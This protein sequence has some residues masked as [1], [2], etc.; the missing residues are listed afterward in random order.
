[1]D[2]WPTPLSTDDAAAHRDEF[3]DA[4]RDHAADLAYELARLQGAE[5]GRW[6][7]ETEGGEWTIK[8]EAGE[9]EFL[10]YDPR[11]GS[12]TYVVSTRRPPE[13]E[14][15][16]DAL[17]EYPAFVTA[18]NDWV[19]SLDG[20]FDGVDTDYPAVTTTA[21]VV[22]ERD[23]ILGAIRDACDV[24]AGE[25]QRY[26]GG[27]FGTFTDRVDGTRWEL[28]WDRDGARFL[29]IG[30][31]NG[32]YLLSSY[33]PPAATDVREYAPGFRNFVASYNDHVDELEADL[34]AVEF[35]TDG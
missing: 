2:D 29:R 26:E 20:V 34:R 8:H 21:D 22:A 16:V 9:L 7:T 4:V 3:A 15:L 19:A 30:G 27:E 12:E 32:V 25:F 31:E 23:R 17:A 1:M 28:K 11:S 5:Y 13:P 10:L 18:F 14:P 33:E 35:D 6:S 24:M